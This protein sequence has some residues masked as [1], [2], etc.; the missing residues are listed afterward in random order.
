[1]ADLLPV[2]LTA[3][4][5]TLD[6]ANARLDWTTV[7]ET[8][9][10]GFAIE[11]AAPGSSFG[12]AGWVDGNGTSLETH[13]YRFAVADLAPGTHRFRLRQ[14]DL[15][16]ATSL[17]PVVELSVGMNAAALLGVSPSPAYTTARVSVQLERAQQARVS[18]FDAIGREVA[19]LFDGALGANEARTLSLDA[20]TLPAGLYV[21]RL[22]G[23]T[24]TQT[25]T[26]VVAR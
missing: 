2:E 1:M 19:V 24:V 25:R 26:L 18:V 14:T 8:N 3:F 5:A 11:H 10:A 9:N 4:T 15:D 6:G 16:G 13:S 23:E 20:S 17:S 22:A 7:S 21:V 12:D